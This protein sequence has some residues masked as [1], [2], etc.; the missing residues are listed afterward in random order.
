MSDTTTPRVSTERVRELVEARTKRDPRV[1]VSG[2]PLTVSDGKR[3]VCATCGA[4]AHNTLRDACEA[5]NAGER[6]RKASG[7]T[8][9][10][11][12]DIA[13]DLLDA[14]ER[15]AVLVAVLGVTP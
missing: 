14:R 15:I 10:A 5:W 2:Y 1:K 7:D 12:P 11:A 9:A 8:L 13:A 3:H 4:V 6:T